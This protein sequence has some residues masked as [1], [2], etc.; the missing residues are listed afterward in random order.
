MRAISIPGRRMSV[1]YTAV[2]EVRSF[3]PSGRTRCPSTAF[4]VV[5]CAAASVAVTAS[6]LEWRWESWRGGHGEWVGVA[7]GVMAR[8]PCW[9]GLSR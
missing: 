2:P 5:R 7:V 1:V 4:P 3:Q 6:G 9:L 8:R